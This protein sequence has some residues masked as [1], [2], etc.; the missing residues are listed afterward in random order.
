MG[1]RIRIAVCIKCGKNP[2]SFKECLEC[3]TFFCDN[4]YP[5]H[6]LEKSG[7]PE[8]V[9]CCPRCGKG[10]IERLRSHR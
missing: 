7:F 10:D 2:A 5:P 6:V 9:N 4:C 3:R 8:L 1:E